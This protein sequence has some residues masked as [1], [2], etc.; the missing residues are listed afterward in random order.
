MTRRRRFTA[1]FKTRVALEA[2]RG[3]KTMQGEE[4]Q[5]TIQ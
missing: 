5:K 1:D 4:D 3:D 2:F